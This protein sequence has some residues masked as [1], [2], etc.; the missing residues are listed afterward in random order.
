MEGKQHRRPW[1]KVKAGW[2]CQDSVVPP[3][4][5]GL[6]AGVPLFRDWTERLEK[7]GKWLFINK[8]SNT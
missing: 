1:D 7:P 2:C 3:G 5:C 6:R 4:L 8:K